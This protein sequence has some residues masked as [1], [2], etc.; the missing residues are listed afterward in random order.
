MSQLIATILNA[1]L[2]S[3]SRQNFAYD[4]AVHEFIPEGILIVA[5]NITSFAKLAATISQGRFPLFDVTSAL[6]NLS[7]GGQFQIVPF[8]SAAT[9]H[10]T[11]PAIGLQMTEVDTALQAPTADLYLFGKALS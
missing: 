6:R 7:T 10:P 2:G 11:D 5:R 9:L 1:D 3:L 4:S 8:T